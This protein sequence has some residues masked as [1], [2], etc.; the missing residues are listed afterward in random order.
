VTVVIDREVR[1]DVAELLVRYATGIDR[2]D[3]ELFRT[4]FTDDCEADYGDI[5]A[6][7]GA[8][9][10]TAWMR[11][12]HANCGHT[13]HRISN[14]AVAALGD[15][16]GARCYVDALIMGPDNRDGVRALGY[17]DDVMVPAPGGWQIARRQFV[18]VLRQPVGNPGM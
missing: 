11:K 6:W 10:L 16:V 1:A 2:R 3:W 9:A 15:A 5:G 8:E 12:A 13:L 18:S 7:Q 14:V 4:C 17:Y